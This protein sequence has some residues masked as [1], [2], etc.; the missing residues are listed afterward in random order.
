MEEKSEFGYGKDGTALGSPATRTCRAE[1]QT[2]PTRF[3]LFR[4]QS[5]RH[6]IRSHRANLVSETQER[7]L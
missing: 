7:P 2:Y 1:G 6:Q 5:R 3:Q 4:A